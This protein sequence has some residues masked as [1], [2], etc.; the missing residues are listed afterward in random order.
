MKAAAKNLTS[1]V[2]SNDPDRTFSLSSASIWPLGLSASLF[3]SQSGI[4]ASSVAMENCL[5]SHK[6]FSSNLLIS[7]AKSALDCLAIV[8]ELKASLGR[9]PRFIA[10]TCWSNLL[11]QHVQSRDF[12][13][14]C[15]L[16]HFWVTLATER[17]HLDGTFLIFFF[18]FSSGDSCPL[19]TETK[20]FPVLVSALLLAW[21]R[22]I[23][24]IATRLRL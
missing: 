2:V 10:A 12:F 15:L 4:F 11:L 13:L 1:R 5:Y 18:F 19:T 3:A 7:A 21:Q 24:Q 9:Q 16:H 14:F 23:R 6:L 17:V 20:R 22:R 8:L